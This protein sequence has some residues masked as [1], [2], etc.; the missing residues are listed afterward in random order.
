MRFGDTE[1]KATAIDVQ[2]G[3]EVHANVDFFTDDN[4]KYCTKL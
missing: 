1:I 3:H 4:P 2:S